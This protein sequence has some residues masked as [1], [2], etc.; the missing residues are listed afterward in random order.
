MP[1]SP[2][3]LPSLVGGCQWLQGAFLGLYNP[4]P[5]VPHPEFGAPQP[6]PSILL[7]V[8]FQSD[9]GPGWSNPQVSSHPCSEGF[10]L[11]KQ[12]E[13]A[14]IIPGATQTNE[15]QAGLH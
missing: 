2:Q 4:C 14:S 13:K 15:V 12:S 8:T 10:C 7:S 3:Q 6:T 1:P 11:P 5:L 9:R